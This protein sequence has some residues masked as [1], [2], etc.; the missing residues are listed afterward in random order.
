MRVQHTHFFHLSLGQRTPTEY[1]GIG[2]FFSAGPKDETK[3]NRFSATQR[4]QGLAKGT[5][6]GKRAPINTLYIS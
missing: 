2:S 4:L 1:E 6:A 5:P 3:I